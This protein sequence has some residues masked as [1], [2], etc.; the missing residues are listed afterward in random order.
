MAGELPPGH[1]QQ[2]VGGGV[3]LFLL[4]VLVGGRVAKARAEEACGAQLQ[5]NAEMATRMLQ[6]TSKRSRK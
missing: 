4:G 2:M 6:K 1:V 5:Y 3:V